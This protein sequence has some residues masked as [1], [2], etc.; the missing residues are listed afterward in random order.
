MPHYFSGMFVII[1]VPWTMHDIR[2][3]NSIE[4]SDFLRKG[5]FGE[6]LCHLITPHLQ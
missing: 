4:N 2:L 3:A 5:V 6:K 1:I